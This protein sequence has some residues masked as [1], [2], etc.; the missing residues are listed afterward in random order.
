MNWGMESGLRRW[1][2][3]GVLVFCVMALIGQVSYKLVRE[4]SADRRMRQRKQDAVDALTRAEDGYFR[5]TIHQGGGDPVEPPIGGWP[6]LDQQMPVRIGRDTAVVFSDL[7]VCPY[8]EG[9]CSYSGIIHIVFPRFPDVPDIIVDIDRVGSSGENG[10]CVRRK[11][12]LAHSGPVST[13]ENMLSDIA[14][15]GARG[16]ERDPILARAGFVELIKRSAE[17]KNLGQIANDDASGEAI[18]E[19]ARSLV[20]AICREWLDRTRGE[21]HASSKSS[22][23]TGRITGR[24]LVLH[25]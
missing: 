19:L 18:A 4:T 10:F 14:L 23:P 15:A 24:C 22:Q 17:R 12:L 20:G 11:S 2:L 5:G 1:T 13:P 16:K 3:I 8:V 9:G 21:P 6:D 7:H 25:I